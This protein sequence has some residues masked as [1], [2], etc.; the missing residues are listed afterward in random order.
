MDTDA[1]FSSSYSSC[2]QQ[3]FLSTNRDGNHWDQMYSAWQARD[4][5]RRQQ[6]ELLEAQRIRFFGGEVGE[7]TSLFGPM[8]SIVTNLFDGNTDYDDP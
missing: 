1:S 4:Q 5:L 7:D 6:E 8:L 3:H 2:S